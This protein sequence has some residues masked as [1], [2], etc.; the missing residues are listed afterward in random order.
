MTKNDFYGAFDLHQSCLDLKARKF[1]QTDFL[2]FSFVLINHTNGVTTKTGFPEVNIS[3][4]FL[5]SFSRSSAI[6]NI[7]ILN[8]SHHDALKFFLLNIISR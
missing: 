5:K 8:S 3:K 7:L 1:F 2:T 4:K 6:I